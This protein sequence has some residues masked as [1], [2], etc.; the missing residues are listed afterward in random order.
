MQNMHKDHGAL[1]LEGVVSDHLSSS[2]VET[3]S[4]GSLLRSGSTQTQRTQ[5]EPLVTEICGIKH[6]YRR[7]SVQSPPYCVR[8][9]M[10]LLVEMTGLLS[11]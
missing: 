3:A 2:R 4:G 5:L 1:S 11:K 6:T 8:N 7:F 9:P 10:C